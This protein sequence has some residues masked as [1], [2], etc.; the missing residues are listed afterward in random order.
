[1]KDSR[2]KPYLQPGYFS[3]SVPELLSVV[4]VAPMSN[5]PAG[6]YKDPSDT[7]RERLWTGADW[8]QETRSAP[9]A[10]VE[11][12][13]NTLSSSTVESGVKP[14]HSIPPAMPGT[15]LENSTPSLRDLLVDTP[16]VIA[17]T[18]KPRSGR[19]KMLLIGVAIF[20]VIAIVGGIF[21]G[22]TN[23]YRRQQETKLLLELVETSENAMK[24]WA[25]DIDTIY[26]EVE[27]ICERSEEECLYLAEDPE[28]LE[29]L[30]DLNRELENS[31]TIVAEQFRGER[32]LN[33]LF[34][35]KDVIL[36]RDSYLDH[37]AAWVRYANALSKDAVALFSENSVHDDD[38]EPTFTIACNNLRRIKDSS[39]YPN[40]SSNNKKRIEVIC[41]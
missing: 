24:E 36:A 32:G 5:A 15:T 18:A 9:E 29:G 30:R 23:Q 7:T 1:M 12:V 10:V 27:K 20:V 21:G 4:T 40:I 13:E 16:S 31:L 14:W 26:K 2:V 33:I 41:A 19:A 28:F 35:H 11:T 39:M 25:K 34:W 8:G 38:I 22:Q 3:I 17:E 37:N 6:W